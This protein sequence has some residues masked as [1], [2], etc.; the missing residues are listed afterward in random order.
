[1]CIRDRVNSAVLR[2]QVDVENGDNISCQK[3]IIVTIPRPSCNFINKTTGSH[4]SGHRYFIGVNSIQFNE[5]MH[6]ETYFTEEQ[7]TLS[8]SINDSVYYPV[9]LWLVQGSDNIWEFSNNA[10][11]ITQDNFKFRIDYPS[12]ANACE[13]EIIKINI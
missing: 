13:L 6:V 1:M 3:N 9:P 11:I 10:Q 7:P 5:I 12:Q 2:A 4:Y 8:F